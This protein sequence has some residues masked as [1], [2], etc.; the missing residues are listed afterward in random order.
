MSSRKSSPSSPSSPS[1]TVA[2]PT[3]PTLTVEELGTRICSEPRIA[4]PFTPCGDVLL[5]QIRAKD[6]EYDA[7]YIP[8]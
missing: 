2:P 5:S 3:T 7:A 6:A 8:K 4:I 1:S